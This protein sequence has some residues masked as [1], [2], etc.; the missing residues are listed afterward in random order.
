MT[1]ITRLGR[2]FRA[3]FHAV[4]DRIEEPELLLRQAIREMEDE[5]ARQEQSIRLASHEESQRG[6][7]QGQ[8]EGRLRDIEEKLDL[9]F[10][11]GKEELARGLVRRKLET[12]RL[13]EQL[14]ARREALRK[15]LE[16]RQA[17]LAENR[18]AL[19]GLRQKAEVVS[20]G[21]GDEPG[22]DGCDYGEEFDR[23]PAVTADDVE[24]AFL[25]EKQARSQP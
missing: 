23:R 8:L 9:C 4:L 22:P 24:V 16:R 3:D 14:A 2:L 1:V 18:A 25:R 17:T 7:R 13:G 10:A 5:L 6:A 12:Q 11:S 20:A 21:A 19:E 15:G